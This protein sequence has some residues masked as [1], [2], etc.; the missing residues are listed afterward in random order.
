MRGNAFIS[1]ISNY[2]IFNCVGERLWWILQA[3]HSYH[4]LMTTIYL[5]V[6][7]SASSVILWNCFQSIYRVL[8][9]FD[10]EIMHN[11]L[12][13]HVD[14]IQLSATPGSGVAMGTFLLHCASLYSNLLNH[15]FQ[16]MIPIGN[17]S[18]H[19]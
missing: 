5:I 18:S 15:S 11:Y 17:L 12:C 10:A 14:Y 2:C 9:I 8:S 6:L 13:L 1:L 7:E 19:S 4:S 3:M 16:G